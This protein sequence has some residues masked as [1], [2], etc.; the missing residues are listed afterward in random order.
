[1]AIAIV[2]RAATRDFFTTALQHVAARGAT[3]AW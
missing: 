3:G 1:L 2:A